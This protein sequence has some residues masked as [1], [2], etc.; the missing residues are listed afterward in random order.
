M[1]DFPPLTP[2]RLARRR[3]CG[4]GALL[5]ALPVA[6]WA[7]V[8]AWEFYEPRP[9]QFS[10]LRKVPD[11]MAIEFAGQRVDDAAWA[12]LSEAHQ[13]IVRQAQKQPLAAGDEPP[14]P[15]AGLRPLIER[16]HR[17]R[18]PVGAP[19]RL[20]LSVGA[21]GD[22]EGLATD[23]AVPGPFLNELLQT[24]VSSGF[25]PARCGGQACAGTLTLDIVHLG[26]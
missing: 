7:D 21:L 10:R 12:R 2:D 13:A 19:L 11:T 26:N 6:A 1:N 17:V 14:Y 4:A 5:L 15:T 16:L 23:V 24:L 20:H 22:I 8:A 18:G 25:K 9:R 3:A